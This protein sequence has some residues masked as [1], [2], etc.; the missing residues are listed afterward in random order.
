MQSRTCS[1]IFSS[2]TVVSLTNRVVARPRQSPALV[3]QCAARTCTARGD[4]ANEVRQVGPPT[5]TAKF[6]RQSESANQRATTAGD[7]HPRQATCR[8]SHQGVP[9]SPGSIPYRHSRHRQVSVRQTQGAHRR[10]PKQSVR[11]LPVV[12]SRRLEKS[13]PRSSEVA[14]TRFRQLTG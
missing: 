7:H 10:R 9:I 14:A 1:V 11:N 3:C 13:R 8:S 12:P 6:L 2:R 5:D 4:T